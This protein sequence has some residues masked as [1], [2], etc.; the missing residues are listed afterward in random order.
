MT[1]FGTTKQELAR[2]TKHLL[3]PLLSNIKQ[4]SFAILAKEIGLALL[5]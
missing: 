4:N 5:V 3:V 2:N 1:R